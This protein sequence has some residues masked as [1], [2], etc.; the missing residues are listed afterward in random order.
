MFRFATILMALL[1]SLPAVSCPQTDAQ[2]SQLPKALVVRTTVDKDGKEMSA[3]I[4]SASPQAV[5]HTDQEASALASTLDESK[6]IAIQPEDQGSGTAV[7]VT[8]AGAWNWNYRFNNHS[9]YFGYG[10]RPYYYG[11]YGYYYGGYRYP[12]SYYPY[13]SYY[14]YPYY[15]NYYY[16][17]YYYRY[18]PY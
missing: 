11:N 18:W 9:G 17:P 12:Y 15:Y 5:I 10:Y 4:F 6:A 8:R 14:S 13:Y 2:M 1:L 16:N 3:V 7:G